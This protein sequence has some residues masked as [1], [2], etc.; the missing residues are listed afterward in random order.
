MGPQSDKYDVY[1]GIIHKERYLELNVK[2]AKGDE[3]G[4]YD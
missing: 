2:D 4:V 1:E 3:R